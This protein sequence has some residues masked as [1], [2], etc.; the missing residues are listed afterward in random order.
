MLLSCDIGTLRQT[1]RLF[2]V[3]A[4]NMSVFVHITEVLFE[5]EKNATLQGWIAHGMMDEDMKSKETTHE[6]EKLVDH[7]WTWLTQWTSNSVWEFSSSENGP[8][9]KKEGKIFST[10]FKRRKWTRVRVKLVETPKEMKGTLVS[11]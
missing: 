4:K 11:C 7:Q 2:K 9:D 6:R 3:N 10:K 5:V 8:Y 1:Q